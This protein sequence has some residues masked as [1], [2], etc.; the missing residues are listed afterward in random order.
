MDCHQGNAGVSLVLVGIGYQGGMI[1][2]I[3]ERFALLLSFGCSIYQLLDIRQTPFCFD[4]I[5]FLKRTHISRVECG[6]ANYFRKRLRL[7]DATSQT[8]DDV[9]EAFESICSARA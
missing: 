7:T 2:K 1:D 6:C 5:L 4:A 8:V 3:L 9:Q